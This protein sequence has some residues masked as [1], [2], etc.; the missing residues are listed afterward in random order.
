M[1]S[2]EYKRGYDDALKHLDRYKLYLKYIRPMIVIRKH[3]GNNLC[4]PAENE[5]KWYPEE[6]LDDLIEKFKHLDAVF[7]KLGFDEKYELLYTIR[8]LKE[9]DKIDKH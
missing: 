4:M 1:Q 2:E 5:E 8:N 3:D 6:D 9:E 7:T